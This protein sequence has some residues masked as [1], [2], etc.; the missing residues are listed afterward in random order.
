MAVGTGGIS[1]SAVIP[2]Y[3][4]ELFISE[5]IQSIL[6]QTCE[7]SE[8]IVVDDG[9]SD[10]T[11][12]VAA[13]FPRTRVVRR[14]NGGQA[15][16]RNTGVD[17][18]SGEWIAFI[19]HDD[20]WLPQKTEIQLGYITPDAGVVHSNRFDLIHFGNLWHRQAHVSPSGALVRRQTF[21]EVGGFEESRAVMGVEDLTLWLKIALTDWRFVKSEI[22]L[23][24][25]RQ[26]GHNQSSNE[27]R[28]AR[29]DL[30]SID[31]AGK[32]VSCQPGEIERV[33]QASRIE[34]AKNL[35]A[36]Q[37]WDEAKQLLE[38]CSPGLASSW[39]SLASLVKVNRLARTNLVRR[40][41]SIDG[42]YR[43]HTCSGEC[44]LTEAQ[45]SLC[46]DSCHRPYFRPHEVGG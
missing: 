6:A 15:A 26:T 38:E 21:L 9:S 12:E 14:S 36:G 1:V 39:L 28:M 2:A 18:A 45:R 24:E 22:G 31:I 46:M 20:V 11:A 44:S 34:Y 43:S 7:I 13:G 17:A 32:R 3:N 4:A 16:A 10:R 27:L 41:H 37:R 5:T 23:F 8:I 30:A 40:L 33:K 29:A 25:W 35:I 42:N 19:D